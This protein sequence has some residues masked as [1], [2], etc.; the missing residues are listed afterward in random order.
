MSTKLHHGYRLAAGTDP[1]RFI[2]IARPS[3]DAARDRADAALLAERAVD[4][5]DGRA[6]SLSGVDRAEN[7]LKAACLLYTSPSPRD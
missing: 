1:F 4:I 5:I 3:L 7:G 2:A 6:A